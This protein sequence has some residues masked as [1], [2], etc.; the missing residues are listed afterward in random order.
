[1][2]RQREEATMKKIAEMTMSLAATIVLNGPVVAETFPSRP[3]HMLVAAAPGGNLDITARVFANK[4]TETL[5]QP[6]VVENRTG[7]S[8]AVAAQA[9]A[10]AVPDGYTIGSIANTFTIVPSVLRNAGYD[11]VKD[12]TG[13]GLM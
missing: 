7:A 11:P 3:I 13:I 6:V 2:P 4:L 9:V 1:M 8:G 12:F 5:G 10:R